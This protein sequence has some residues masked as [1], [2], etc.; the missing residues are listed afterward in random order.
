MQRYRKG[1]FAFTCNTPTASPN[2]GRL[3]SIVE[4]L[5]P[6]PGYGIGFGYLV[7]RVDGKPFALD[8][9]APVPGAAAAREA[10]RR[11]FADEIGRAHV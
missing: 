7:E 2:G 8:A 9:D 3:V 5:G 1:E 6:L 11:V 10:P 4:V